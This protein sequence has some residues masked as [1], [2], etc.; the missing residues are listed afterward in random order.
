MADMLSCLAGGCSDPPL[1]SQVTAGF[2]AA[3]N[4]PGAAD[5]RSTKVKAPPGF[6]VP[7]TSPGPSPP[8]LQTDLAALEAAK[9]SCPDC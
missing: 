2:V 9:S 1:S 5:Q 8:L 3:C 4:S 6:S 7:P